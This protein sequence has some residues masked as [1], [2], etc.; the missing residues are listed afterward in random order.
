VALAFPQ[1]RGL[2]PLHQLTPIPPREE[3]AA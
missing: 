3:E 2:P 1:L